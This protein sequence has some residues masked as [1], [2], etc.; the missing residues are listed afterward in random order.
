MELFEFILLM[1]AAV[2]ALAA[3]LA[4]TDAVAVGATLLVDGGYTAH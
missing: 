4:P 2:F 1:L 3:A